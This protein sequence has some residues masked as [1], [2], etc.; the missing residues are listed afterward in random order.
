MR[1]TTQQ[2]QW[3]QFRGNSSHA[4][5]RPPGRFTS[6]PPASRRRFIATPPELQRPPWGFTVAPTASGDASLQPCRSSNDP[7]VA[8]H[9]SSG[10]ASLQPCR[11]SNDPM[12]LHC[13]SGGASLQPRRSSNDPRGAS[14]QVQWCPV[15]LHCNLAE[16]PTT[17]AALN[18]SSDDASL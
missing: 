16:A 10:D 13:S 17:T 11:S 5:Q 18:C 4:L 8:L 14:L 9:C 7:M 3:H 2:L 1:S 15:A 6:P 12:A